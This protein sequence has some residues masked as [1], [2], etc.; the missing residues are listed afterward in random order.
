LI[1]SWQWPINF[2]RSH[3][4]GDVHFC[5]DSEGNFWG[6]AGKIFQ[7]KGTHTGGQTASGTYVGVG[8]GEDLR[9]SFDF[10]LTNGAGGQVAN[11]SLASGGPP[12]EEDEAG[13]PITFQ[14]SRLANGGVQPSERQ[15]LTATK[16]G[17]DA[18]RGLSGTW[19]G[20]A[21]PRLERGPSGT[22]SI[23]YSA[24]DNTVFGSY[25]NLNSKGYFVGATIDEGESVAG[26]WFEQ[27]PGKSDDIKGDLLLSTISRSHING[28]K[29]NNDV[30]SSSANYD[31]DVTLTRA[32]ELDGNA[33]DL[34]RRCQRNSFI[35]DDFSSASHAIVSI[36]MLVI[37]SLVVL[38]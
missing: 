26:E 21:N 3:N 17:E 22:Y 10:A 1:G 28:F 20:G 12:F 36:A 25:D 37:V 35:V 2:I 5:G 19:V 30:D 38:F 15:C 13:D 32:S 9:G 29:W 8:S 11:I 16:S 31:G 27:R 18:T 14:L 34:L 4:V 24:E 7:F 23:C 33:D 6:S